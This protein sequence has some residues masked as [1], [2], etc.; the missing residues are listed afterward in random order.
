MLFQEDCFRPKICIRISDW[1]FLC[2]FFSPF[3]DPL[4]RCPEHFWLQQLILQPGYLIPGISSCPESFYIK[5][6][7]GNSILAMNFEI[8]KVGMRIKDKS[9]FIKIIKRL[10]KHNPTL[11]GLLLLTHRQP[12]LCQFMCQFSRV[13]VLFCNR[14]RGLDFIFHLSLSLSLTAQTC[15]NQETQ[16]FSQFCDIGAS[17]MKY[18]CCTLVLAVLGTAAGEPQFQHQI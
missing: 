16:T 17:T 9:E 14:V 4:C 10:K 7:A 1:R 13:V 5:L 11:G 15:R 8:G 2:I 6:C 12:F 3:Q 18:S